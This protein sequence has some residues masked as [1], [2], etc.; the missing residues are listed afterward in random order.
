MRPVLVAFLT[1]ALVLALTPPEPIILPDVATFSA[2]DVE[3][4]AGPSIDLTLLSV[5]TPVAQQ[6]TAQL[7][8]PEELRSDPFLWARMFFRDWDRVPP[9][10]ARRGTQGDAEATT[11]A[12]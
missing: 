9:A 11:P 2:R 1:P 4:P 6:Q 10:A 5:T 3:P 8:T 12:G 7:V